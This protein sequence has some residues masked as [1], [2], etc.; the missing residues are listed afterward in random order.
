MMSDQYKRAYTKYI[1]ADVRDGKLDIEMLQ[2]I[3]RTFAAEPERDPEYLASLDEALSILQPIS[4]DTAMK[5]LLGPE[6]VMKRT[7]DRE[8]QQPKPGSEGE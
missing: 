5:R 6:E 1:V 7:R 3:Q 4:L 2:A 8:G